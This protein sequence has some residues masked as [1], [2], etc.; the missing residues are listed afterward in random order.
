MVGKRCAGGRHLREFAG[1]IETGARL[2]GDG[3]V[4]DAHL[5]AIA[6]E[7]D[8]V[9]PVAGLRRPAAQRREAG[10][11]KSGQPR[12]ACAGDLAGFFARSLG[13]S[14][15]AWRPGA[16]PCRL[17]RP[18]LGRLGL[19]LCAFVG[20]P[21]PFLV[22]GDLVHGP[23]GGGRV[24][25][26]LQNIRIGF[27]AGEFVGRLDQEPWLL[28]FARTLAHAHQMPVA[29][30]LLAMQFEIEMTL[31]HPLVRIVLR[32]PAAAVPD[33]H[34]AAAVLVLWDGAFEFVVLDRVVLDVDGEAL[35]AG[36][37]ARAARHRP[38]QHHA[39]EFEAKIVM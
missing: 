18:G 27:F 34:G 5:D 35:L 12:L 37:Q 23:A 10:F 25:H 4:A 19:L 7:L 28:S 31:L 15:P 16:G 1:P 24:L 13:R 17:G 9:D 30:Q 36:H 33:H 32:R 6:V 11:D 21:N 2:Q 38:A 22:G 14:L 29:V 39:V 8:L 3:T 20:M 26:F